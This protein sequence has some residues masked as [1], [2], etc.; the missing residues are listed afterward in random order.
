MKEVIKMVSEK[1]G[2]SES[3]AKVAV[4]TVIGFLKDKMP[5]GLGNQVE[6]YLNGKSSSKD[7]PLGGLSDQI[8]GMFGKK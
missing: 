1:A 2:V 4:E 8:G 3:T 5:A 6:S 7:N